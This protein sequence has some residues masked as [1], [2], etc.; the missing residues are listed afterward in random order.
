MGQPRPL[1]CLF[2][3][4][5]QTNIT[6]FTTNICE[7]MSIQY[8]VLDSNPQPS[9][10]EYHPITTRPGLHSSTHD[11]FM[12]IFSLL[13]SFKQFSLRNCFISQLLM[14]TFEP[15]SLVVQIITLPTAPQP[16]P[17]KTFLS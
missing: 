15:E 4:F 8:T 12:T 6:I 10:C 3:S 14:T 11:P 7:K 13:S 5:Q 2:S 1:F 16:L 9:D 17:S